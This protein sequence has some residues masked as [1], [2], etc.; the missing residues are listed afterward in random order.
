[1]RISIISLTFFF[2][3]LAMGVAFFERDLAVILQILS[4]PMTMLR[5]DRFSLFSRDSLVRFFLPRQTISFEVFK[6]LLQCLVELA[7]IGRGGKL[8]F[9]C[10][11]SVRGV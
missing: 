3:Q 10:L 8:Y 9:C 1:L 11:Y 2:R 4:C 7:E 5:S 6:L